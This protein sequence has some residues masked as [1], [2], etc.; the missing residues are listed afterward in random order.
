MVGIAD[1]LPVKSKGADFWQNF[2]TTD[3]V[4]VQATP[5]Q[6]LN[7]TLQEF[8]VLAEQNRVAHNSILPSTKTN[9]TLSPFNTLLFGDSNSSIPRD[10]EDDLFGDVSWPR[11][12]KGKIE[13]L[14]GRGL[15][16]N[17]VSS[18]KVLPKIRTL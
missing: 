15:H 9:F 3:F 12:F 2:P 14:G 10:D 11:F 18:R 13:G 4:S 1:C 6:T 8:R 16:R 17:K 7:L 5:T